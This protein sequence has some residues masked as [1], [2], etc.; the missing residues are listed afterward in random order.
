MAGWLNDNDE[1]IIDSRYF[2]ANFTKSR[3][4]DD[5]FN[6]NTKMENK[7]HINKPAITIERKFIKKSDDLYNPYSLSK[8]NNSPKIKYN[9]RL[10]NNDIINNNTH[11]N[12]VQNI[13]GN[14]DSYRKQI[15]PK[16][17]N[18]MDFDFE[19]KRT[20]PSVSSNNKKNLNTS[21]YKTMPFMGYDTDTKNI[22][23]EN[24]LLLGMPVRTH[25]SYGYNNAFENQFQ[26]ISNDIQKPENTVMTF[27][28]GGYDTR[29]YNKEIYKDNE[30]KREIYK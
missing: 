3:Y 23:E 4:N 26:Y 1:D 14:Y 30:Y 18:T 11:V 12:D 21:S 2:S 20:I 17:Q 10:Y 5:N 15:N 22:N 27:P 16:F 25:K 7:K 9:Q 6:Q 8:K 24:Q 19:H 28:R 13:I 29:H